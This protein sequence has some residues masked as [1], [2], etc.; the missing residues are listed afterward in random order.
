IYHN[1]AP[2]Y[3]ASRGFRGVLRV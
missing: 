1:G 3:Y 2:S